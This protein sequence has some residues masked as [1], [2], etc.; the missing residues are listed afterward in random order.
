MAVSVVSD[1][2]LFNKIN[3]HKEV[4]VVLS[5]VVVAGFPDYIGSTPA[6]HKARGEFATAWTQDTPRPPYGQ[7]TP[8]KLRGLM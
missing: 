6:C 8:K 4:P 1:V 3:E 7:K 5:A 2:Q